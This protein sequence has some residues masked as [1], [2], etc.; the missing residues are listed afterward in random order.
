MCLKSRSTRMP[1]SSSGWMM[2]VNPALNVIIIHTAVAFSQIG[3]KVNV[4]YTINGHIILKP[5]HVP[6]RIQRTFQKR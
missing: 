4:R 2:M 6:I 5:T 3:E 1:A